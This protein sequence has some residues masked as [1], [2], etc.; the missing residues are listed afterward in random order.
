MKTEPTVG[1]ESGEKR[2]PWLRIIFV[3]SAILLG[4]MTATQH[5]AHRFSYHES[6]GPHYQGAYPPVMIAVWH[7]AWGGRFPAEFR[8]SIS[9][10]MAVAAGLLLAYVVGERIVSQSAR[11]NDKLHGTAHWA[12][13]REVK[14]CGLL[15]NA[16]GVYVGSWQDKKGRLHYLRD[17]GPAHVLC[18]APT[19]SGKGVGLVLP[20]LLSWMQSTVVS[21]LK[22]ELWQLT[23]GW[24]K[25]HAGSGAAVLS[26]EKALPR[27]GRK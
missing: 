18:F 6:L 11:G 8:I 20:T 17:N 2:R 21:D 27:S 1:Y 15:N 7:S 5:F 19:R 16:E 13:P 9:Y 23:S 10:G 14:R 26:K 3:L 12:T 22:G 4:M 24:R 25:Q